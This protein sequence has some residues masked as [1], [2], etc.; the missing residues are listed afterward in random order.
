MAVFRVE[1]NS[2]YTVMSNYHFKE[3][4]MSLKAKGLLSMMLSLPDNWD[5]SIGGL[6]S[7]CAEGETAVKSALK[8]L[9]KFGYLQMKR[10]KNKDGTFTW[11]YIIYE[12]P[13]IEEPSTENPSMDEPYIEN[14]PMD[15]LSMEN[16]PIYKDTN[17]SSINKLKTKE[18]KTN[19]KK[20]ESKKTSFDE[21]IEKYTD[22][23]ELQNELKNHLAV[24]KIKK[25]SLT[26]RA[27][28]LSFE[29]LDKLTSKY[30][31]NLQEEMKIKIVQTSIERGWVGFFEYQ[32][33]KNTTAKNNQ[34]LTGN[35]FLDLLNEQQDDFINVNYTVE[36]D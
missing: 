14:P 7:L 4:E 20:K 19:N 34:V 11:E 23:K 9:K 8:E 36:E 32:E 33:D 29:K 3:K 10:R 31:I 24:R 35:P 25:G 6:V 30:P 26:N 12:I 1:K 18:L 13:Q 5:Y 28:E 22:N 16:H 27:I 17:S 15:N 2:N 21:L